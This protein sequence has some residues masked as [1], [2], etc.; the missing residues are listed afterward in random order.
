VKKLTNFQIDEIESELGLELPGLYRKLLVEIGHGEYGDIEIY[1]PK[2]INGLYE[3]HFEVPSELFNV[4]FPFGCNNR[5]QEIWLIDP[6]KELAANIWHETHPES[7]PDEG[8]LPYDQW[9][10]EHGNELP[11]PDA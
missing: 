8:W 9:I 5:T 3:F 10:L 7:Y 4:F 11:G 1:H 6:S 2:E